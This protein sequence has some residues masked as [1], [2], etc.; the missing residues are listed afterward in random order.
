MGHNS[1]SFGAAAQR[2]CSIPV[3]FFY[4][5]RVENGSIRMDGGWKRYAVTPEDY[6][7]HAHQNVTEPLRIIHNGPAPTTYPYEFEHYPDLQ[8]GQ[9]FSLSE[10]QLD[11]W[12]EKVLSRP[13]NEGNSLLMGSL[14]DAQAYA[15]EKSKEAGLRCPCHVQKTATPSRATVFEIV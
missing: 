12:I 4:N 15:M 11:I 10:T 7:I 13:V 5:F 14:L 3:P 8:H 6:R 2:R 9:K 1:A